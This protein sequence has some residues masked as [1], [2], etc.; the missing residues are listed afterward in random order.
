MLIYVHGFNSSPQSSKAAASV[1]YFTQRNAACLVPALD[2]QPA[3]AMQALR[4]LCEACGRKAALA[5]SSLGGYYATWLVENGYA[6]AAVLINPAVAAGSKLAAEAGKVQRNWHTGAEYEFTPEHVAQLEQLATDGI[7]DPLR[8]LLLAQTG[9]EVLDWREADAFYAGC[10]RIIEQG[11]E[12]GFADFDRHLS[13]IY[14][15][16]A[17]GRF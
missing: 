12:H 8:Y 5:G 17:T 2:P 13:R 3:A 9:D 4:S 15:L 1:A 6:P 16:A 7:D 10:S 11:G 14:S